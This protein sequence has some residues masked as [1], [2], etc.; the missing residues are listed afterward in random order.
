M[1]FVMGKTL[2]G[3]CIKFRFYPKKE[4]VGVQVRQSYYAL[5]DSKWLLAGRKA[6][7]GAIDLLAAFPLLNSTGSVNAEKL[8]LDEQIH[9]A[10][11]SK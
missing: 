1:Y 9:R 5:L 7:D 4:F 3:E 8:S 2:E 10:A 6:P 11:S